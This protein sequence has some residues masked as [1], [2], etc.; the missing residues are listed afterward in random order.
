MKD[1]KKLIGRL[2]LNR[3]L[4]E[5]TALQAVCACL[6]Y[7][8]ADNIAECCDSELQNYVDGTYDCDY[9]DHNSRLEDK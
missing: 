4:L 2:T 9:C 3:V 7:E 5:R 6:Y 1:L 8:L